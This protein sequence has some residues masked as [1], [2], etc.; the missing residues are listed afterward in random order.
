MTIVSHEWISI[1]CLCLND[2]QNRMAVVL[3]ALP[4]GQTVRISDTRSGE[5][6]LRYEPMCDGAVKALIRI[7]KEFGYTAGPPD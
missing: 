6:T 4:S 7:A 3:E 2:E 1:N 5:R